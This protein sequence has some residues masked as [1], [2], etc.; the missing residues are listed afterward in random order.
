MFNTM[1]GHLS[2]TFSGIYM[3]KGTSTKRFGPALRILTVKILPLPP[4]PL[5]GPHKKHKNV[6]KSEFKKQWFKCA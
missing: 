4:S 6:L 5:S 2:V 3:V 1:G